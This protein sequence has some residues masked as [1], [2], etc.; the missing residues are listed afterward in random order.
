MTKLTSHRLARMILALP[1]RPVVATSEGEVVTNATDDT[2]DTTT[3]TGLPYICLEV[4][5]G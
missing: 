1:D 5:G 4:S 3:E 2:Y